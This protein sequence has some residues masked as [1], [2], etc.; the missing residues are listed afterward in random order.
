VDAAA[1]VR[2]GKAFFWDQQTG[3]DGRTACASCH[4]RGGADNRLRNAVNPGPDGAFEA[5]AGPGMIASLGM[6]SSDDRFGSQGVM[7]RTFQGID[8]DPTHAA[9]LCVDAPSTPFWNARQ[10]TG[11][12]T[13]SVIG[14]VFYRELFWDGRA[15]HRFNGLDPFGMTGN[16]SGSLTDLDNGGPASQAVGPANS[17]VEM[18]C[19]GRNFNGPDSLATKLLARQPLQFQLVDPGDGVLGALSNAPGQGLA[20]G[21]MPCIYAQLIKEAFGSG[22][23]AAATSQFSRIWG[24]AIQAYE[25]TLVPDQTP[26]DRYLA[27]NAAALTAS[28]Q[29]GLNTF[30]G[31][32]ECTK[33]HGGP[34]LSDATVRFGK[35]AG[36]VNEDGGD[37][38]FHNN[39]VRPTNEDLGRGGAGPN[40]VPFSISGSVKDRGAVKTPQLRN[41]KLTPPYFHN[42][43]MPTLAAVVDFYDRG[44]DF[45]DASKASRIVKL[46]LSAV[47]R[48]AL[49]DFLADG[50]TDCRVEME[51]APFDHPSLAVVDGPMLPAVGAGG[52]G[53]CP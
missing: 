2:L 1:A 3:S 15:S 28:Q 41:V 16:A 22:L 33:C 6:L 36:L 38:G 37:Q 45:T 47:D 13:P 30:T 8:P 25:W 43:G 10:V 42:G 32:G 27:G 21:G 7:R 4:F 44:G 35:L 14:A 19:S 24:Q 51:R 5:V 26:L 12:N 20:C 52:L 29:R 49:V 48:A 31:K 46:N 40:G 50:L 18:A 9:D 53:P 34:E 39:G 23:A 17:S 11:R